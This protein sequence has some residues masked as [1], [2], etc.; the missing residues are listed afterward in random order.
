ML[1]GLQ[2]V[3]PTEQSTDKGCICCRSEYTVK[4]NPYRG[5]IARGGIITLNTALE[6]GE[7]LTC[8]RST[9]ITTTETTA[10]SGSHT[11]STDPP[12]SLPQNPLILRA[13]SMYQN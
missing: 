10:T 5:P 6:E 12:S 11:K 1:R 13:P 9:P 3:K 7:V 2:L 8:E 4:Y